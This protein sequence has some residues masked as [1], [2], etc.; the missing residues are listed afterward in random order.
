MNLYMI[1]K[2]DLLLYLRFKKAGLGGIIRKRIENRIGNGE[3]RRRVNGHTDFYKT[4][5]LDNQIKINS[6]FIYKNCVGL[7]V[8]TITDIINL[9]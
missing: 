2:Q 8:L 9:M 7:D 3:D 5:R 6:S 1:Y 4:T